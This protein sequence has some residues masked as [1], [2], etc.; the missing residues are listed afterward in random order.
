MRLEEV[1]REIEARFEQG[2]ESI[3]FI[4][5]EPTLYPHLARCIGHARQTGFKRISICT[6]GSRLADQ[7]VLDNLIAAGLS[8]VAFSI[9]SHRASL[10]DAITRRKGSFDEKI[11]AIGNLVTAMDAGSLADGFSFNSVLHRKILFDLV[12]F[13][14]FFSDLGVRDIRFNFIRPEHQ[15]E[16]SRDWVPS[17]AETTPKIVELLIANE[18]RLGMHLT[19]ADFPLCRLP[20]E[21]LSNPQLMQ[22]YVGELRDLVTEVT[23]YSPQKSG[24][25]KRFNWKDQ[26]TTYL[27]CMLPVCKSCVL[28]EHCEGIWKGYL[29]IYGIEEFTDGPSIAEACSVESLDT[30]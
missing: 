26:R 29:D 17:F 15:A 16:G 9:H 20:W 3:G 10:G 27:K 24:G 6:N 18:S 22:R 28:E 11:Q 7:A 4:G 13:T 8:R 25:T 5:G 2:V 23:L 21:V 1:E 19:F 14:A 30:A 12:D